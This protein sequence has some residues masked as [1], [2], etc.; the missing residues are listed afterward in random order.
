MLRSSCR[1]QTCQEILAQMGWGLGIGDWGLGI[2]D[3]GLGIGDWG[4]G[5][6][7][8]GLGIGD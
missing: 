7:G 6:R 1:V 3:W 5:I 2:G 8:W 4:L